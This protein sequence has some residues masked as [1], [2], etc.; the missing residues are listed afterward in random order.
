MEVMMKE[1]TKVKKK[2]KQATGE[3]SKNERKNE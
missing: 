3:G 1:R 2:N